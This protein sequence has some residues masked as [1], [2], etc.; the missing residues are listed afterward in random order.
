MELCPLQVLQGPTRAKY[1][2]THSPLW[3]SKYSTP[4]IILKRRRMTF[5]SRAPA[6]LR[7][8]VKLGYANACLEEVESDSYRSL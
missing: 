4:S 5:F 2:C 7:P 3:T 1:D 6:A 8:E